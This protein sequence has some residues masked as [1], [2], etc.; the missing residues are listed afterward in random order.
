MAVT[1]E[2]VFSIL[3]IIEIHHIEKIA[4][5][6]EPFFFFLNKRD[7]SQLY[8]DKEKQEAGDLA[9][10]K[11]S[12]TEFCWEVSSGEMCPESRVKLP[13]GISVS[14]GHFSKSSRRCPHCY[15]LLERQLNM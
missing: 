12:H 11:T 13:R 4:Y 15:M 7:P 1:H 6:L 14:S 10:E 8:L 3:K 2:V 9:L 5:F